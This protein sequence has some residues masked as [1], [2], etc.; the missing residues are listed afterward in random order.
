[1]VAATGRVG[2]EGVGRARRDGNGKHQDR[3]RQ[4]A[5]VHYEIAW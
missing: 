1:L 2:G 4:A 3:D 5:P